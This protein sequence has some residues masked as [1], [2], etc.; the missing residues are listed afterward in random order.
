MLTVKLTKTRPADPQDDGLGSC[1]ELGVLGVDQ[2]D[3][4]QLD[5]TF[6]SVKGLVLNLF[7]VGR[8]LLRSA[9]RLLRTRA[10]IEWEAVTCA[11]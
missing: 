8:H 10:F 1:Q 11:C 9:H 5:N 6:L 2:P 7:R 3:S 4:A